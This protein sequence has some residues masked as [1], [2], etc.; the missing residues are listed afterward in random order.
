MTEDTMPYIRN[1]AVFTLE[2]LLIELCFGK[3][4]EHLRNA[5]NPLP[6]GGSPNDLTRF[7]IAKRLLDNR[8][9]FQRR[10]TRYEKGCEEMHFLRFR[11]A[12]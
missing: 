3:S 10:G 6:A 8:E 4:I 5:N 7:S 11:P 12:E 1:I 9:I 2:L